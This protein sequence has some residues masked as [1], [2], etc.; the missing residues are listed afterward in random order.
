MIDASSNDE[1]LPCQAH[2]SDHESNGSHSTSILTND[3]VVNLCIMIFLAGKVIYNIYIA[4]YSM[5]GDRTYTF[6][7]N[8]KLLSL[9]AVIG[10][11]TTS[12]LL[13]LTAYMLALNNDKQD[14]LCE[15]I[16]DYYQKNKVRI[17]ISYYPAESH[18]S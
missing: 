14:A 3:E 2:V 17:V 15:A 4:V 6:N 13:T 7:H 16:D 8:N 11:E 1:K 12:S 18:L 5:L 10:Y 9:F